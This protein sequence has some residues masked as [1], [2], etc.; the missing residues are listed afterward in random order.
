[1]VSAFKF[2]YLLGTKPRIKYEGIAT[3]KPIF[4]TIFSFELYKFPK[5]Q[6]IAI[7]NNGIP[8]NNKDLHSFLSK[9][10]KEVNIAMTAIANQHN[11]K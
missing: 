2:L 7:I 11:E 3:N 10:F 8:I 9:T 6:H 4:A 1:M 5:L